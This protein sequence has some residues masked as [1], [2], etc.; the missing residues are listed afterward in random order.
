M[1]PEQDRAHP[2]VSAPLT[3]LYCRAFLVTISPP[4]GTG[5]SSVSQVHPPLCAQCCHPAPRHHPFL[6]GL[7]GHIGSTCPHCSL[8][9]KA[10]G[11]QA[12]CPSSEPLTGVA[13]GWAPQKTSPSL[14]LRPYLEKGSLLVK[15][16]V[17]AEII[18]NRCLWKR[19]DAARRPGAAEGETGALHPQATRSWTRRGRILPWSLQRAHSL[20]MPQLQAYGLQNCKRIHFCCFRPP[21]F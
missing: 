17:S 16:R 4:E 19:R 10:E 11:P 7:P 5:L 2:A 8:H 9:K 14:C 13:L 21:R 18:L 12:G 3:L 6:P 1:G 20:A 15:G